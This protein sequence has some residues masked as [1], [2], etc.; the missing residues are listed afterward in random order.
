MFLDVFVGFVHLSRRE[1]GVGVGM[2]LVMLMCEYG[3]D[4]GEWMGL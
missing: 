4:G 2:V 3:G 1:E